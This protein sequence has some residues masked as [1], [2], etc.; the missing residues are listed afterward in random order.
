[1]GICATDEW[2]TEEQGPSPAAQPGGALVGH[3]SDAG[4]LLSRFHQLQGPGREDS[5]SCCRFQLVTGLPS[6]QPA[7]PSLSCASGA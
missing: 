6:G 5:P 2:V 3:G 7:V 4:I 1:M